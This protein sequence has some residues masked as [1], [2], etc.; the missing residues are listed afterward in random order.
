MPCTSN[1]RKDHATFP[2]LHSGT[3]LEELNG[4]LIS[5]ITLINYHVIFLFY[6]VIDP[7]REAWSV[8]GKMTSELA[9]QI[10]V[11]ELQQVC[12]HAVHRTKTYF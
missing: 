1:P 3:L 5:M 10:Y 2:N 7:F 8:C 11:E 4:K 6:H 9:M 12:L